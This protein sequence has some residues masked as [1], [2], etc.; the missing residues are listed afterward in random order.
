MDN[1]TIGI[2]VSKAKLDIFFNSTGEWMT[3]PNN[4]QGFGKIMRYIKKYSLNVERTVVEHTGSYQKELVSFLQKHNIPV[5]LVHPAK[6]RNYAKRRRT[7][8]KDR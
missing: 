4:T 1:T 5:S 3:I 8:G 6:V 2:D 7:S